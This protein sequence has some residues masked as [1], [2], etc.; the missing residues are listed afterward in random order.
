MMSNAD[1]SVAT[2]RSHDLTILAAYRRAVAARGER[3]RVRAGRLA[4]RVR[5]ARH[6]HPG[7]PDG[8]RDVRVAAIA[9]EERPRTALCWPAAA[10][11]GRDH[12]IGHRA[13]ELLL[14]RLGGEVPPSPRTITVPMEFVDEFEPAQDGHG[15]NACRHEEGTLP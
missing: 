10:D 13:G 11:R 1:A 7:W 8:R 15:G 6:A 12:E 5:G 9:G 4:D 14:R 2:R 3:E